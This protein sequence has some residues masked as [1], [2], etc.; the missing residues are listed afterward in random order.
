MTNP[1]IRHEPKVEPQSVSDQ[2]LLDLQLKYRH[3]TPIFEELQGARS[4]VSEQAS[5][6]NQ[7]LELAEEIYPGD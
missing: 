1:Y 6:F 2:D 3:L 7:L 4:R 5:R